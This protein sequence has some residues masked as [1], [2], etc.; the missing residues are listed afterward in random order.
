[1]LEM[2]MTM[3]VTAYIR[4]QRA[5]ALLLGE[6]LR[7]MEQVDVLAAPASAAVPPKIAGARG[8]GSMDDLAQMIRFTGPFKATG[9]PAI[10]LPIGIT[11]E[12]A[13]L[14]SIQII[15]RPFDE[16]GVLRVADAYERARGPLPAPNLG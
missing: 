3:P 12:R 14:L 9:Q 6:A 5:R 7:A 16:V 1:M 10:A 15:G 11:A 13:P 2:A 8:S 4:A